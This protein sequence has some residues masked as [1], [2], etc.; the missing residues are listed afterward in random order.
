MSRQTTLCYLE[1]DGCYLMLHRVKKE[2]DEN[3][4][5]WIGVGGKFEE[6]E[7]PEDCARREVLE[8]TGLTLTRY[9][10]RGIVTFVSDV[11]PCEYMHLFTADGFSGELKE[12]DEGVLEWLPKED[13]YALPMWAG[14]RLFLELLDRGAP[15]FSL[16]LVYEG[17]ILRQAALNGR[18]LPRDGNGRFRLPD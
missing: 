8:E 6:G 5:K 15:F 11:W 13:V 1:K 14:D 2:Q 9:R 4:D 3:K 12:C 16:K 7:S 18:E 10:Y 17:E